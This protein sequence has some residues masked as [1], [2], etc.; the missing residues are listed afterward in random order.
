MSLDALP[1]EVAAE[2]QGLVGPLRSL[3]RVGGGCIHPAVHLRGANGE[4]FLKWAEQPGDAGFAVEARGL[5]SLSRQGGVP[6]PD[7][8]GVGSGSADRKGWLLLEWIPPGR[9]RTHTARD[10][11]RGLAHLHRPLETGTD[12]APAPGW[13]E[14]GWIATLPQPNPGGMT[15]PD[16]WARARVEPQWRRAREG[17]GFPRSEDGAVERLLQ[18]MDEALAGWETDGISILHGDLWSGNVHVARGGRPY[19]VDP[20]A[21]RGHREV[22]LAML[23]LF[24]G[25]GHPFHEAYRDVSPAAPGHRRRQHVYQLYPLLVHVN[26]FGGGYTA[27]ALSALDGALAAT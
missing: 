25:F 17:G 12:A 16:F 6:V 5:R 13:E 15:W 10:L 14:D 18:R 19:L 7:V 1:D 21:Y 23:D 3:Q 22:D 4:A 26:L 27:R 24:G 9:T 8:L 11:G 2:V 20:A